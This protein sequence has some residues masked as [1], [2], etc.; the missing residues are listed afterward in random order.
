MKNKITQE[1]AAKALR[2][3]ASSIRF[4]AQLGDDYFE[5]KTLF[6]VGMNVGHISAY[7]LQR[8]A[9]AVIGYEPHP[10][11]FRAAL[12]IPGLTKIKAALATEI[13]EIKLTTSTFDAKLGY[14]CNA[15]LTTLDKV[16]SN[17]VVHRVPTLSF[18]SELEEFQPTGIKMDIEGAEYELLL[19]NSLPDYVQWLSMEF[20][21]M[22]TLGAYLMPRVVRR[23]AAVG[24]YPVRLPR[25]KVISGNQ[26][27][28]FFG[29]EMT[30][31]T[32][33]ARRSVEHDKLLDALE[34]AGRRAY[35]DGFRPRDPLRCRLFETEYGTGK[36]L[37]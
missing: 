5:G 16:P 30:N 2:G 33:T 22:K 7:M 25:I 20:H 32:R 24:L 35:R 10:Y 14:Y 29:F 9:G 18:K 1:G 3:A 37:P 23:L 17:R 34:A 15:S 6:D 31:F 11:A 8:G 4:L 19:N 27:N 21:W 26:T 28:S 12:N 13:G 36:L